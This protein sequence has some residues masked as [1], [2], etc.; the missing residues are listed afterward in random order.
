MRDGLFPSCFQ[1]P[2]D[3]STTTD[4]R[5]ISCLYQSSLMEWG[6]GCWQRRIRWLLEKATRGWQ[7][8]VYEEV[9]LWWQWKL[10]NTTQRRRHAGWRRGVLHST[11]CANKIVHHEPLF[12]S[13]FFFFPRIT[14]S[15]EMVNAEAGLH[16][17]RVCH[18][19][20]STGTTKHWCFVFS[21]STLFTRI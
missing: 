17:P 1:H 20:H 19:S 9:S 15:H 3:E 16:S 13:F 12:L 21:W 4:G 14:T 10:L 7:W 11:Y 2:M 5:T 18:K 8:R 6:T